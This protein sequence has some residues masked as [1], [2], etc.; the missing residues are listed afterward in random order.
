MGDIT[1][2]PIAQDGTMGGGDD[3]ECERLDELEGIHHMGL[4]GSHEVGVV[5]VE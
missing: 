5:V 2:R 4:E 1:P 3:L